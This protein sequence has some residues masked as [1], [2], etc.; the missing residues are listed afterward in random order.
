MDN[1]LMGKIEAILFASGDPFEISKLSQIL[2]TDKG[3]IDQAIEALH[4]KYSKNNSGIIML[5]LAGS[6]Q[7]SNKEEF[8]DY[9]KEALL[10][11]KNAPLSSAA[12]EALSIIAY[13]QP[14]PVTKSFI[15][16]IRGVDSSQIVNSLVE[17]GLIEEA[18]RHNLPGRPIVYRTTDVFLRNFGLSSLDDLPPLPTDDPEKE[19]EQIEITENINDETIDESKEDSNE[20]NDTREEL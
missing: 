14:E 17:K 13:N 1:K 5:E 2:K 12:M 9:I 4:K 16:Q 10:V 15:E 18:G 6:L 20:K 8:G 19:F 11:K 7:L 3:S